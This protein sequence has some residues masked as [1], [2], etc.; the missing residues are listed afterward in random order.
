MI[1][2][3]SFIDIGLFPLLNEDGGCPKKTS[4]LASSLNVD[5]GVL[6]M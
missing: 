2:I 1:A 4:Y 5:L 6:S 3:S